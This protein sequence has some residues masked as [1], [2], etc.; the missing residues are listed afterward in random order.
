M[1]LLLSHTFPSSV[2]TFQFSSD[3]SIG[4][5]GAVVKVYTDG[6]TYTITPPANV[7]PENW[8]VFEIENGAIKNINGNYD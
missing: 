6:R 3:G 4:S 2:K 1:I 7:D 8:N 5:S